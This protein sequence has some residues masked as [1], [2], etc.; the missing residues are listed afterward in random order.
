MDGCLDFAAAVS[1]LLPRKA[2]ASLSGAG[3][4]GCA[5]ACEPPNTLPNRL[6][7][8]FG[9][10]GGTSPCLAC[11]AGVGIGTLAITTGVV[12][13]GATCGVSAVTTGGLGVR[14]SAPGAC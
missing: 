3:C 10:S 8:D 7:I 4:A 12:A 5:S 9:C 13:G 11:G 6:A 2:T 1:V 14:G